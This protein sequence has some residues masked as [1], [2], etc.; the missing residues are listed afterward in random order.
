MGLFICRSIVEAH[1]GHL[2]AT[3]GETGGAVFNLVLPVGQ[4]AAE[5]AV[6]T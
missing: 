1:G 6:P 3:S 5:E 4:P 2:W